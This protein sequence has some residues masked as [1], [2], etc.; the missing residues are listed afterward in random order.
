MTLQQQAD[1]IIFRAVKS[2][3]V[4]VVCLPDGCHWCQTPN[5]SDG[6]EVNGA[7]HRMCPRCLI[8]HGGD[9]S[10]RALLRQPDTL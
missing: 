10:S 8:R 1:A 5:P 2:L 9:L 7:S 4:R 3:T 6:D